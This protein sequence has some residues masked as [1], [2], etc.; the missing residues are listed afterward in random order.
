MR[1]QLLFKKKVRTPRILHSTHLL[2]DI[3]EMD[4]FYVSYQKEGKGSVYC[5]LN[6][7]PYCSR[8]KMF[9]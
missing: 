5:L 4:G 9:G 7:F 2:D 3:V 8:K 6:V 1:N